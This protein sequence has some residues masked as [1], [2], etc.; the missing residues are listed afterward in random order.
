M[1]TDSK[2][3]PHGPTQKQE[4][5]ELTEA[6]F[7]LAGWE[8]KH[9]VM[10]TK[11]IKA[12][13]GG[14]YYE[15]K[16]KSKTLPDILNDCNEFFKRVVPEMKKRGFNISIDSIPSHSKWSVDFY[17]WDKEIGVGSYHVSLL[18]AGVTAAIKAL[19]DAK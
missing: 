6:F 4:D 17:N 9:E 1:F 19:E 15:N 13:T 14:Y 16:Y 2:L 18:T 10:K 8:Y 5:T 7:R 12:V 3:D 11:K